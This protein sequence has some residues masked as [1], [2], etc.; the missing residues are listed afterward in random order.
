MQARPTTQ[1]ILTDLAR[2]VREELTLR[3]DDPAISV[4]LEMMEQLLMAAAVRAAHEIAWMAEE[5]HDMI[6]YAT[7]VSKTLSD[8]STS[9][10]LA[11]YEAGR[12]DSLH[13]DDQVEN[14]SLAGEAFGLALEVAAG[15][16]TL[17]PRGAALI[18]ARRDTELKTRPD[19][20]FPG[21]S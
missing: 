12:S 5:V 6:E 15:H 2:E 4:N 20:Y 16:D 7:E 17:G 1:Q 10:A 21:R 18:R 19:F 11:A 13:L 8:P 9:D 14:Y 3:I